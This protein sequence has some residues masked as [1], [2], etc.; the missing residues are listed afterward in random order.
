[1]VDLESYSIR[2]PALQGLPF[3]LETP[4]DDAGWAEEIAMLRETK[5]L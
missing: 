1:M 4:N 3:I 5:D 2:H